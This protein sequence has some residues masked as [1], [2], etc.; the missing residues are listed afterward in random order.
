MKLSNKHK[1]F[2][3]MFNLIWTAFIGFAYFMESAKYSEFSSDILIQFIGLW[4]FSA[5]L[6][7][8]G[9]V[10]MHMIGEGISETGDVG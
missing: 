8:T 5:V 4:V 3:I 1:L 2:I 10:V 9:G 7:N 6:F